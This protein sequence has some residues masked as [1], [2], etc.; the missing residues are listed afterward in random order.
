MINND[1][2]DIIKSESALLQI[3]NNSLKKIEEKLNHSKWKVVFG[4][5][6]LWME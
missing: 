3:V 2:N 4:K 6:S 1:N 5:V